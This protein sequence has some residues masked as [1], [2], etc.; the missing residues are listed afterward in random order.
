MYRSATGVIRWDSVTAELHSSRLPLAQWFRAL[1]PNTDEVFR[2]FRRTV[3]QPC[4]EP[5][6]D[7][8]AGTAGAAFDLLVR[9]R[10]GATTIT[11]DAVVASISDYC[12]SRAWAEVAD[13][14]VA[15]VN[16]LVTYEA[17][18]DAATP[19]DEGLL[20]GCWAIALFI[21]LIRGVRIEQSALGLIGD[22]PTFSDVLDVMPG[23]A[24]EDL[25]CLERAFVDHLLP[26]M[27]SRKGELVTGPAFS[28][29]L[30][31]DAD[32]IKGTTLI[33]VKA[34]V[35][36][37]RRDGTPR[38]SVDSR[39]IYQVLAYALLAQELFSVEEVIIFNARY[40][41]VY[42]WT[43]S[44]LLTELAGTEIKAHE[45]AAELMSF[46]EDPIDARVPPAARG[47]ALSIIERGDAG[48]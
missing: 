13:E 8:P 19:L 31:G 5:P 39:M 1:L 44:D 10:L 6:P 3:V 24:I 22:K 21:E 47:A 25:R 42:C 38:Y 18:R 40:A 43:L 7:V 27:R 28:L 48:H 12:P 4:L 26:V 30:P 36:R 34:M 11:S 41:H 45:L 23:P 29:V 14:L 37:R 46:L 35:H 32:L 2:A 20:R 16:A 33:E 15:W 9:C 17:H